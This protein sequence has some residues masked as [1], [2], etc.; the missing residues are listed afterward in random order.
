MGY[1]TSYN[2]NKPHNLKNT[3]RWKKSKSNNSG[4]NTFALKLHTCYTKYRVE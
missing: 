4:K 3:S 1:L 2:S